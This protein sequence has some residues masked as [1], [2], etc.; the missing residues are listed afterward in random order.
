MI[1]VFHTAGRFD[2]LDCAWRASFMARFERQRSKSAVTFTVARAIREGSGTQALAFTLGA[3][4]SL[5]LTFDGLRLLA[6]R[7]SI[8]NFVEVGELVVR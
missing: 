1:D 2:A 8:A 5:S 3:L 4:V 7:Q 6:S